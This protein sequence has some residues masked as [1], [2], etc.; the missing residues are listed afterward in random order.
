LGHAALII[1]LAAL[2]SFLMLQIAPGDPARLILGDKASEEQVAQLNARFGL[3]RPLLEQMWAYMGGL[4]QGDL[5]ESVFTRQPV[6]ESIGAALPYTLLLVG[7][8]VL[9]SLL[10]GL[11]IGVYGGLRGGPVDWIGQLVALLGQS[12][13]SFWFGM[14]LIAV[15]AVRFDLLPTSGSGTVQ[16]L[17]LPTI[18]L[19]L[20]LIGLVIRVSRAS[21]RDVEREDFVRT[22]HSKGLA[23]G[24]VVGQHILRNATAP[25]LTI[26]AMYGAGLVGGA[27]VVEVVFAW[28]GIGQL[29][30]NAIAIRD[31]PVV[32]GVVLVSA[33]V[34]VVVNLLVD[35]AYLVL[36]PRTKYS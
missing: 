22:A 20:F 25:I 9:V 10:V 14:V 13:P 4:L 12:I 23:S 36:D 28:P 35:L 6:S 1:V 29:A 32:Q 8:A 26:V 18:T 2:V 16:H 34:F 3:D 33:V 5:G 7:A 21:V 24:T 30:V 17:V 27:V 11:P 19:A 15:V 31:Y